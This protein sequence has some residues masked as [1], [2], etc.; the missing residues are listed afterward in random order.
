MLSRTY[1]PKGNS[2]SKK[3]NLVLVSVHLPEKY[4]EYLQM[5]VENGLYPSRSEAIRVAVRD[6]INRE[7]WRERTYTGKRMIA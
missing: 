4:V 7:L 2:M 3:N 5:L 6:L 1:T